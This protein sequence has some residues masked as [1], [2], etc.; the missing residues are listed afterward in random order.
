MVTLT[1]RSTGERIER[2]LRI[3]DAGL[4]RQ[5]SEGCFVVKSESSEVY[6]IVR[7]DTGCTCPD[8]IERKMICKH[9]WAC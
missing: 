8:A 9:V 6:Y 3:F 2:G 1:P 4:V 7:Q 5:V